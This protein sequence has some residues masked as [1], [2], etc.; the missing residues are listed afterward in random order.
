MGLD[1]FCQDILIAT[2][3]RLFDKEDISFSGL[4][5]DFGQK[6]PAN[7]SQ[8]IWEHPTVIQADLYKTIL[9]KTNSDYIVLCKSFRTFK[10]NL[11]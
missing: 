9:T 3:H 8:R 11:V 10:K 4:S 5:K 2:Y 6:K 1:L 7:A